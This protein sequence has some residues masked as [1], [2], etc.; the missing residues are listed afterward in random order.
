[1]L[2]TLVEPRL[3]RFPFSLFGRL[4]GRKL[5]PTYL[6]RRKVMLEKQ[7]VGVCWSLPKLF[8]TDAY[9]RIEGMLG[10]VNTRGQCWG[11]R[12]WFSSTC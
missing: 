10:A 4:R 8:G 9:V 1:M 5:S 6:E 7:K 11:R 3:V 12:R 2:D